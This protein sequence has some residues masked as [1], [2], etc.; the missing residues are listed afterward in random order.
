MTRELLWS[1]GKKDLRVDTFRAGGKGG[2]HQNA[3]DSGVRIT[4]VETG[5]S[6]ESREFKSQHQNKGAAFRKLVKH[7]SPKNKRERVSSKEKIRTYHGA[8]GVVKDHASGFKQPYS[9][10]V[11]KPHID[12]MIHARRMALAKTQQE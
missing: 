4:P 9:L 12:D 2:Q 8:R 11:D 3:T 7:Y 5:L 10:V 6:A 1:V